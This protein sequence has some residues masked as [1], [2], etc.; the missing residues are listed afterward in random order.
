MKHQKDR[1]EQFS[2]NPAPGPK[3]SGFYFILFILFI[4]LFD[5][6]PHKNK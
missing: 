2:V 6:V 1:R 4:Y 3:Q 5:F